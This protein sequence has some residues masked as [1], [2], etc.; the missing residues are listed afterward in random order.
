MMRGMKTSQ[1]RE[2]RLR[3][4]GLTAPEADVAGAAARL[5][6]VQ[7]QDFTAGRWALAVRTK[8]DARLRDVDAAFDRGDIVRAWTM[9]GTLHTIPARDLGW[10]LEI[11]AARQQQQA[12][13]RQRQLGIDDAMIDAVVRELTPRLRDGGLTRGE[14]FPVLEGIGI[15]PSGQRGIHLLFALT[16][17]G[18]LVQGPVVPREGITREQR[19]VLAADH[20]RDHPRPEDPLAERSSATSRVTGPRGSQTSRGG[21][22]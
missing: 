22:G 11:T 5:L 13:S 21:R 12:A 8:G 2:E 6:A 3:W 20:I 14:I 7:S 1:W 4:Q 15:D 17:S 9:R 10:V 16:V 19:F 18:V